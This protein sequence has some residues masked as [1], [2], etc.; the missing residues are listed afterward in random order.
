MKKEWSLKVP[1]RLRA[2]L[3]FTIFFIIIGI[4]IQSID[5]GNF[6]FADFFTSNYATWF[7]GIG[8]FSRVVTFL[9]DDFLLLSLLPLKGTFFVL[10]VWNI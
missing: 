3:I 8:S 7:R 5:A 6:I 1:L 2:A 4:I 9:Y 10:I